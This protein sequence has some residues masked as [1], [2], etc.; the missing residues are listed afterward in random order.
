M[1]PRADHAITNKAR[2]LSEIHNEAENEEFRWDNIHVDKTYSMADGLDP[3]KHQTDGMIHI[4]LENGAQ[5]YGLFVKTVTDPEEMEYRLEDV[6]KQMG[7]AY[8]FLDEEYPGFADVGA[9]LFTERSGKEYEV[10]EFEK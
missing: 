2:L 6:E 8:E 9:I 3:K 5:A 7:R 10:V 4:L 1:D